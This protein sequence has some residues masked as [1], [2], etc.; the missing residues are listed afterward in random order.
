MNAFI[1]WASF[2]VF[3]TW[4]IR[5]AP[6]GHP[7]MAAL[8]GALRLVCVLGWLVAGIRWMMY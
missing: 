4:I 7:K 3:V 8:L 6:A 2:L 5:H 1:V